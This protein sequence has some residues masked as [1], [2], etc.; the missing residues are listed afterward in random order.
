MKF[1]VWDYWE[2]NKSTYQR[3]ISMNLYSKCA[4]RLHCEQQIHFHLTSLETHYRLHNFK[5]Q[6]SSIKW[7]AKWLQI[8]ISIK[9]RSSCCMHFRIFTRRV[10]NFSNALAQR[11]V[12][13]TPTREWLRNRQQPLALLVRQASG[14]LSEPHDH[15]RAASFRL[16]ANIQR[17]Y[18]W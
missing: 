6:R 11:P 18:V 13:T 3:V 8:S 15:R 17:N 9:M 10:V 16:L 12:K 1:T 4:T 7:S 5:H 14:T 2:A